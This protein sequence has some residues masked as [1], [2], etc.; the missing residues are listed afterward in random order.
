M[1][2]AK[3]ENQL[4]NIAEKWIYENGYTDIVKTL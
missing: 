1:E 3:A 2:S 4:E